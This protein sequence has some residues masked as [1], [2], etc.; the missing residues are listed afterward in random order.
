MSTRTAL[1]LLDGLRLTVDG[2]PT[3][4]PDSGLRLLALLAVRARA[5]P[6]PYLAATLWPLSTEVRARANL[7][8]AVW[9]V[10]RAGPDLVREQ[11]TA[12]TLSDRLAVDLT[13]LDRW[14]YRSIHGT[15]GPDELTVPATVSAALDLFRGWYDDWALAERE[16]MRCRLL[17]ALESM[18][19]LLAGL[20][21]R[22]WPP[23]SC[24]SP[25]WST[26]RRGARCAPP[27]ATR[28]SCAAGT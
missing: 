11:G 6:R 16:R 26:T 12:L 21:W 15:A 17:L 14:A 1:G 13:P 25:E 4:L 27:T 20:G 3:A 23:E 9:R 19:P 18:C 2:I 5:L 8:S 28:S 10:R 24:S 7:R 22:R